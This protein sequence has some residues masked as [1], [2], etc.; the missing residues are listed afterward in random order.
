VIADPAVDVDRA[1]GGVQAVAAHEG[2]HLRDLGLVQMRKLAVVDRDVG[3]A[4]GAV[5]GQAGLRQFAQHALCGGLQ[6]REVG[7]PGGRV[8]QVVPA[9]LPVV[10]APQRHGAVLRH[11]RVHW[12]RQGKGLAPA[13]RPAGDGQHRQTGGAQAVQGVKRVLRDRAVGGQRVVDVGQ[14]TSD[15]RAL[16]GGPQG[17]RGGRGQGRHGAGSVA[18]P[19]QRSGL[20]HHR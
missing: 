9:E 11:D 10:P 6:A 18:Q 3:L 2:H 4:P 13:G 19:Y 15:A 8:L 20:R 12:P 14:H 1:H 7:G 5:G 17:E 16:M